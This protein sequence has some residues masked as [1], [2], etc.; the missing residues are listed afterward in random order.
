[1]NLY[2]NFTYFLDDPVNGDEF[3]QL[4]D[5]NIFGAQIRHFRPGQI[6]GRDVEHRLGL[7]LRYDDIGEVGL[8]KTAARQRLSTV[9]LDSVNQ[10]S[11]GLYYENTFYWTERLKTVAG[12]RWDLFNFDV[13]SNLAVNSGEETDSIF[14]PKFNLVYSFNE[15][16]E[17]F[18]SS[19][20]GY[21]SN[22]ARGTVITVDPTDPATSADPVNPLV[23]S[24]GIETGIRFHWND[25]LN[26]SITLWT[27]EL[28]SE[29]LFVGDAGLTEASRP[30]RRYG[31]EWANFIRLGEGFMMDADLS[32]SEAEFTDLDPAGDS[33]PGAISTV[34][35]AGVTWDRGEAWYGSIRMRYFDGRDLVEDGSIQSGS[36][37]VFNGRIGYRPSDRWSLHLDVLNLFD[38]SDDD[39]TYFYESRLPGEPAEGIADIHSHIIEPRTAR[40]SFHFLF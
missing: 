8:F 31:L 28:D 3:E 34:F 13:E 37:T 27:L 7:D 39:I 29:L 30:S 19:G 12:I 38:S 35:Q 1:M 14:S 21:H 10:F 40:L 32:L 5:R 20:L 16:F 33:I 25:R 9:R 24:Q 26:S 6:A 2:S 22:D 17:G 11:S 15:N 18:I 23:K 36:S 4:D